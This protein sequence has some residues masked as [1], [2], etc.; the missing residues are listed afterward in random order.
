MRIN[1]HDGVDTGADRAGRLEYKVPLTDSKE[2]TSAAMR[3]H[4]G[5]YFV[6][7]RSKSQYFLRLGPRSYFKSSRPREGSFIS[8]SEDR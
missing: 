5:T 2:R 6:E 4:G 1:G 7:S 8:P 3:E